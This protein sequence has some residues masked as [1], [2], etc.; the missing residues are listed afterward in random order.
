MRCHLPAKV[1]VFITAGGHAE[2]AVIF[3]LKLVVR[4]MVKAESLAMVVSE[5]VQIN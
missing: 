1:E 5:S 2:F 3:A 4:M